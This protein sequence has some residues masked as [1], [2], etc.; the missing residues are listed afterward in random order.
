MVYFEV[1]TLTLVVLWSSKCNVECQTYERVHN[2]SPQYDTFIRGLGENLQR[3]DYIELGKLSG[4][5]KSRILMKFNVNQFIE[6]TSWSR[7]ESNRSVVESVILNLYCVNVITSNSQNREDHVFNNTV[8]IAKILVPWN[9]TNVTSVWKSGDELWSSPYLAMTGEDA[10]PAL[11]SVPVA[12]DF[13][14]C[15]N[16]AEPTVQITLTDVFKEWLDRPADNHG[17]LLWTEGDNDDRTGVV[18]FGSIDHGY[19]GKHPK[20]KI[21]IRDFV[22]KTGECPPGQF[23]CVEGTCID[24]IKVCNFI[25]D[26]P[27]ALD[28]LNCGKECDF[29]NSTCSWNV[30]DGDLKWMLVRASDESMSSPIVPSQDHSQQSAQGHYMMLTV[31]NNQDKTTSAEF[32]SPLYTETGPL[33]NLS[34]HYQLTQDTADTLKVYVRTGN[35]NVI[36]WSAAGSQGD[37][38][39]PASVHLG[40]LT[41]SF[42]IVFEGS[43]EA[44]ENATGYVAVDSI[45]FHS[46]SPEL[47]SPV[48]SED[49]FQC[50]NEVCVK[51]ETLCDFSVDC[52]FGEDET[53]EACVLVPQNARCDFE[54]NSTCGWHNV[55]GDDHFDWTQHSGPTPTTGTGPSIDHT[56][57]NE[58]GHYMYI[59]TT[60]IPNFDEAYFQSPLFKPPPPENRDRES[61]YYQTCQ[62]RFFYHIHGTRVG[63]LEVYVYQNDTAQTTGRLFQ[64]RIST[65]TD[66]WL[67]GVVSLPA[68]VTNWYFIQFEASRGSHF[69]GDIAIDDVSLSPECFGI[70]SIEMT[71]APQLTTAN[72]PSIP[73]NLEKKTTQFTDIPK[74]G[75]EKLST[76]AKPDT[77]VTKFEFTSCSARGRDGPSQTQCD[78]AY[79][80]T[81]VH[82]K[83]LADD[84]L[85]GVQM[86]RVPQSGYYSLTVKGASGGTGVNNPGPSK[87]A[88]VEGAF[89][90]EVEDKLY[91]LIGQKGH[92]S[93]DTTSAIS[94]PYCDGTASDENKLGPIGDSAGGGGGG[95]GGSFVFKINATT[96]DVIPLL[97]AGGGGGLAFSP[98]PSLTAA[99]GSVGNPGNGTNG[100]TGTSR[101]VPGGGG[102]LDDITTSGHAGKSLLEG[103]QGGHICH[104]AF[105]DFR[106]LT[107]GGFGG[108]GGACSSGGGGGGYSG[109]NAA[110]KKSLEVNGDGGSSF[111]HSSVEQPSMTAG[112][113][114][115]DGEVTVMLLPVCLP[116]NSWSED[117]TTCLGAAEKS[118]LELM[119]S[120]GI[121]VAI[122]VP[123]SIVCV[124]ILIV[125][126]VCIKK[127]KQKHKN[128]NFSQDLTE[129]Q[130]AKLREAA[131]MDFNPNYVLGDGIAKLQDLNEVPRIN[132]QLISALGHGA[133][134]EV[135]EGTFILPGKEIEIPVAVKTLRE[136]STQEDEM[137]FLMEALILTK[138]N[139]PNIVE[140]IGV[141]FTQPPRFIILEL[142]NGGE[143]KDFLRENRPT[144]DKPSQL[145]MIDLLHIA[146]DI[147]KGCEYLEIQKFI[148]RDIAARN[149]LLTSKGGDRLAKIG[150]F[151][152]ARD[153]YRNDYYRKGGIAMLPVKWMP[154]EAFLDGIFTSKTDVWSFGVLL[155]ET[156]SLGYMPYPGMTNQEVMKFSAQGERMPPPR[157]CPMP[158]YRIMTQ[159]WQQ[160]PENRPNF[161]TIK[162]RL[163]Y[164]LQDPDVLKTPLPLSAISEADCKR[165]PT[166]T[167]PANLKTMPA[168]Q[169]QQFRDLTQ[170]NTAPP[171]QNSNMESTPPTKT[172]GHAPNLSHDSHYANQDEVS[173]SST[174]QDPV[175]LDNQNDYSNSQISF[176]DETES[177]FDKRLDNLLSAEKD[178]QS[179]SEISANE[180]TDLLKSTNETSLPEP[181]PL[182]SGNSQKPDMDVSEVEDT[183]SDTRRNSTENPLHKLSST[184]ESSLGSA[185]T[186]SSPKRKL[187]CVQKDSKVLMVFDDSKENGC[188][189]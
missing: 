79:K 22:D 66:A 91:L 37:G 113:N 189:V 108:G 68:S 132:L 57:G 87:G 137:D 170:H 85:K 179:G 161:T 82:V 34:F 154:P 35:E 171:C 38:W 107:H 10:T 173:D 5:P 168:I 155:W 116:Y 75:T 94:K 166:I 143:L 61:H 119:I 33:C 184:S 47:P 63:V 176:E 117:W 156:M 102:G 16:S 11:A 21:L 7:V 81:D 14:S 172:N 23:H 133:F 89:Y 125:A 26:C 101:D 111:L 44:K 54:K 39:T 56:L 76:Q 169:T 147:V 43:F 164:C 167:R 163:G 28:E 138:F 88:K 6:E 80:F 180:S 159:C 60:A 186:H 74:Y 187:Y 83:V 153:I 162:E 114:S 25:T 53:H 70:W 130:L 3:L 51:R 150:D 181:D 178:C 136:N 32:I 127:R 109:G 141:C 13:R 129:L 93:C 185:S 69:R 97:V 165:K 27:Y 123:V 135:Y 36:A 131:E 182:T 30:V 40:R 67:K 139:H 71:Q 106:W 144:K 98:T 73:S 177:A 65:N 9:V 77:N 46:C 152:M 59:E 72:T 158:V 2:L 146:M 175:M 174:N 49:E 110:K 124:V 17:V 15:E 96:G 126:V 183:V 50:W 78:L 140:C 19:L 24:D 149:I 95:G 112:E 90:L 4:Y 55:E 86:W 20:L 148:H 64:S 12:I 145:E 1:I 103:G 100:Y 142:M 18:K 58:H 41:Q 8:N 31:S 99:L 151:G 118:T 42:H 188:P 104:L 121:L 128:P 29:E 120:V 92:S 115:G 105:E 160:L 122:V 84:W 48:C 134:G 45:I 157:N 62:L 52:L